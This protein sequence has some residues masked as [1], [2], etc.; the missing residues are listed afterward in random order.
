M[1]PLRLILMNP[2]AIHVTRQVY[3][4]RSISPVQIHIGVVHVVDM[5]DRRLRARSSSDTGPMVRWK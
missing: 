5:I 2:L 1:K 3:L 4:A